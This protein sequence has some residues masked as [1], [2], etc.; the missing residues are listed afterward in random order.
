RRGQ[1]QECALFQARQGNA[2]AAQRLSG[3]L[4]SSFIVA[5]GEALASLRARRL[6][7]A[8]NARGEDR[9]RLYQFL[10]RY[11]VRNIQ[12]I[13]P[14]QRARNSATAPMLTSIATSPCPKKVQRNP[15]IR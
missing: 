5:R 8:P 10:S 4:F 13:T 9:P 1:G 7:S 3:R 6:C 15:L 12:K 11:P 14:R 2:R